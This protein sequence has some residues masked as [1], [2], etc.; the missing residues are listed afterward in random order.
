MKCT[1]CE[2]RSDQ[3]RTYRGD[4]YC[5]NCAPH[6]AIDPIAIWCHIHPSYSPRQVRREL[7]LNGCDKPY[8][9][10]DVEVVMMNYE[11]D[12]KNKD[13]RRLSR[14]AQR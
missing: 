12:K 6:W 7:R 5:S 13:V 2:N 9:W 3:G 1:I 10:A 14:K 11:V 8:R 4:W